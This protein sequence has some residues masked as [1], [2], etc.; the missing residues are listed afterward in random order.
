M[1]ALGGPPYFRLECKQLK[2]K[3]FV[4][5]TDFLLGARIKCA[6]DCGRFTT[7]GQLGGQDWQQIPDTHDP[8]HWLPA[9][10]PMVLR[11]KCFI[12]LDVKPLLM[13]PGRLLDI[14]IH[15]SDTF[16]STHAQPPRDY[17]EPTLL[18]PSYRMFPPSRTLANPVRPRYSPR[19]RR[20]YPLTI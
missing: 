13:S 12:V 19:N 16:N 9:K 15:Y 2:P 6:Y 1:C 10:H 3:D 8:L 18:S 5:A 17:C 7:M 4:F 20:D 11:H 14:I